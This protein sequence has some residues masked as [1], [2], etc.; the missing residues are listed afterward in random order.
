M[1]SQIYAMKQEPGSTYFVVNISNI[2]YEV[3]IVAKVVG[4]DSP[5]NVLRD[6]VSVISRE[7]AITP[8]PA[9]Y[10]PCVSHMRRVVDSRTAVVPLDEPSIAGDELVLVVNELA[11]PSPSSR[12]RTF[13]FV[14][15]L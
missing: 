6:V 15:V 8:Q 5:Q 9:R 13:A 2:H 7:L 14:R 1:R 10:V 3:D 11:I 4:H 12:Q